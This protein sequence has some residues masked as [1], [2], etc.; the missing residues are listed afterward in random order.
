MQTTEN[1]INLF[2]RLGLCAVKIL[3]IAALGIIKGFGLILSELLGFLSFALRGAKW[4]WRGMTE[5]IRFRTKRNKELYNEVIKAKKEGKS[6]HAKAVTRF[7][8]SFL[9]G[10]EGVFYTMFNYI[11]PIVSI[12]FLVAVVKYGSGLEYGIAVDFNGKEIGIISAEADFEKAEREVQ[13]RISYAENDKT[14]NLSANFSLKIISDSDRILSYDQLANEMLEASDEKLTEAWGIY[15]D[16]KFIAAVEDNEKIQKALSER[17]LNYKVDGEVRDLSYKNKIEYTQGIYLQDSVMEEKPAIEMLT[18]STEK[19]GVYIAKA[20][21]TSVSV[22]QMYNMSLED[23]TKLNPYNASTSLKNG[24]VINVIETESFLPIKYVKDFE[25]LSF[26]DYETVEY[27]TSALNVGVR[28]VLVKGAVGEK[29]SNTEV[30]YVDGIE[31][32]RRTVRSVVTKEPVIEQIGIGTYAARPD[33]NCR[34]VT[35]SGEMGWPLDGGW[36]SDTFISDRNHKGLD[37]AANEGTDIYAAADGVVISAGWNSGGYGYMVQID[38]LN[39]YQ[40]VYG[41]MS[42]VF[43]VENQTVTKGQL[44]GA[45]GDTGNSYGSHLHFEVRYMGVC[46][47]PEL[48]LN[49]VDGTDIELD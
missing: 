9:F 29:I 46:L 36:I 42:S 1:T 37:I 15:I 7:A 22:C 48:F 13:Q 28:S 47:D 31:R 19:K 10:E 26:L 33:P 16:G 18:S 14:L 45:V 25:T 39:G 49:T 27:E 30:T 44:I 21:D 11:M 6:A 24:Q 8:G 32:S 2:S 20:G 43:A 40:T 5:S 17:L 35:G 41:H 4:F 12:A 34:P 3:A 38:H 23:F